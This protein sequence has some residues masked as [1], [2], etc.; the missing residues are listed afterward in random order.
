MQAPNEN[1][2]HED[3]LIFADELDPMDTEEESICLPTSEDLQSFSAKWILK[4]SETRS[5]TRAA[6]VGIVADTADLVTYVAQCLLSEIRSL[7][8][9]NGINSESVTS[10]LEIL[11][12]NH[13]TRPFDG[14]SSFRNQL[15]YY[16]KHFG[17]IVSE[18]LCN[19]KVTMTQFF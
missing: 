3:S 2:V 7:L 12:R 4:T 15:Q 18:I 19:S 17:L 14:L 10:K 9:E 8:A 11:F 6:T 13:I 16:R 5:L 1:L